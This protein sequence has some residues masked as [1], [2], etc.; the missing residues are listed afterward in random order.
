MKVRNVRDGQERCLEKNMCDEHGL[1]HPYEK[2]EQM[3]GMR[4]ANNRSSH[5]E[6]DDRCECGEHGNGYSKGAYEGVRKAMSWQKR[7]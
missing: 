1:E 5:V 7:L 4:I 3:W 2:G 6:E